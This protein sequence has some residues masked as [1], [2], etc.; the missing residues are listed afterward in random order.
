MGIIK[1]KQHCIYGRITKL[2]RN[3]KKLG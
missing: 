1:Y 3:R 2:K